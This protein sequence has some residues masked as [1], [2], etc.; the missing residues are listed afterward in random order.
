LQSEEVRVIYEI[1]NYHIAPERF[2]EYCRWAREHAVPHLSDH[3][4]LVG[5]WL[6]N[7]M[8]NEVRGEPMDRLG[9]ANVTW[10]IAWRDIAQ[11]SATLDTLFTT[12]EWQAIF[13]RL[14]GGLD[15]YLR[16]ESTFAEAVSCSS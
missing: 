2:A 9:S 8:P 4:D 6:G 12:P 10:I 11:R 16:M 14:P 7:G 13:A 5:F 3:L 1:R 15:N